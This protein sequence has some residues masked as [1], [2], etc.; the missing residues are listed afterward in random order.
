VKKLVSRGIKIL[1]TGSYLPDLVVSNSEFSAFI[2]TDD[3]WIT[4]RTGIK[5]RRFN[6]SQTNSFMA[7]KA[8]ERALEAAKTN[9]DEIDMIIVSTA[10]PDYFYTS[11]ACLIQSA[12]GAK[13][14]CAIDI[15][16]ACT[17][18]VNA[19]DI[20]H[21]YLASGMYKKI[22][23]AASESISKQI[24]FTD[25]TICVL[26]GDG[27]GAAVVEAADKLYSSFLGAAGDD[28]DSPSLY[29]RVKYN[30]NNPFGGAQDE[31]ESEFINMRGKDIY[32]FATNIMP[33][34]VNAVCEKAGFPLSDIDL[35]IPHQ[36]NIRIINTAMKSLALPLERVY[37]NLEHT[38][39][40]SSA[41]IPVCLDEL[42]STDR[43][44]PG[45]KICMA[46]FGAGLTYGSVIIEV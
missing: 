43:I 19:L 30:S 16:A 28:Y 22:L 26:F 17:G 3:K 10:T 34:A 21:K 32:R 27:A 39:N 6:T 41:C 8:S 36:A 20:A 14:A 9:A 40:I 31:N 23:V 29:Y 2:E 45:M 18:F 7:S 35:L 37:T 38:G 13:N 44:K 11:T 25:R 1:G 12:I 15:S 46:A 4:T 5:Q 24:D 42:Y 33:R